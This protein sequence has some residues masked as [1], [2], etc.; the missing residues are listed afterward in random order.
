[1]DCL[2]GC[3]VPGEAQAAELYLGDTGRKWAGLEG[4]H[5]P[6]SHHGG[7]H[8]L[9]HSLSHEE[10]GSLLRRVSRV[11]NHIPHS[12]ETHILNRPLPSTI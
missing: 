2:S 8:L 3:V 4:D 5:T 12:N 11:Q 9:D 6:Q 1:M 10:E 7:E